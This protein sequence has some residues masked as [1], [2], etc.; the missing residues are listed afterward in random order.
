MLRNAPICS[1][2]HSPMGMRYRLESNTCAQQLSSHPQVTRKTEQMLAIGWF[3]APGPALH[4]AR[5]RPF[6]MTEELTFYKTLRQCRSIHRDK[7][8]AAAR[9]QAVSRARHQ[10]LAGSTL[11]CDQNRGRS[12]RHLP[13]KRE[14]FLHGR[15]I[16]DQ[17]AQN[18]LVAELPAEPL[19]FFDQVALLNRTLQESMHDSR[20]HRLFASPN[21]VSSATVFSKNQN[22]FR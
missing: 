5:E 6:F 1:R 14:D 17:I 15:G 8:T 10:F 21:I 18:A 9:A 3:E 4:R 22:A 11:A 16:A 12:R 19:G 2:R 13:D 20:L 7:G